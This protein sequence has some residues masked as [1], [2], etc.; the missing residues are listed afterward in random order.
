MIGAPPV[1]IAPAIRPILLLAALAA[2][3]CLPAGPGPWEGW[4][5]AAFAQDD[6]DDDDGGDDGSDDDDDDDPGDDDPGDDAADDDDDSAPSGGS[7]GAPAARDDTP[8]RDGD[9]PRAE[10]GQERTSQTRRRAAPAPAPPPPPA[11]APE[12]L[13]SDL[14]EADLALLSAEGFGLLER[15]SLAEVAVTLTRLSAPAG[16]TLEEARERVRQ[17]PSGQDADFNHYFRPASDPAPCAHEN[18]AALDLAGWPA[19]RP[20]TCRVTVPV[21]LIDTGVNPGHEILAGARLTM[22]SQADPGAE[23]SS[24][25][26]GTAVLS[27]LVGA[28]G[29]RVPGLIHEAEV[30]GVDIFTRAGGD[31]R[32]D[33]AAV[34]RGLDALTER[35]VRLVN[36]AL[37][38]PE[39]AVLRRVLDRLTA[40]EGGPL[41]GGAVIVAAVGNGGADAPPALP[42]AHQGVIAVTAVDR[43]G[44][45]YPRAQRGPHVDLAAPGVGLL[46]ATS[47]RGARPREGTSFAAPFVTAA[48]ALYLSRHPEAGAAEVA[49][50]LG[51]ASR[52]LGAPGPDEIFGQGLLSAAALCGE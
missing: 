43:R 2:G 1:P 16:L 9:R 19:E 5:S 52:D 22:L 44:R 20:A 31:E 24:A 7:G 6:D 27:L 35:G 25:I 49:E 40:P 11:F 36:M 14:S 37:A 42:A 17:L 51:A 3:L 33:A 38:G 12:L 46:A 32:A 4:T 10:R 34:V 15:S 18:C 47:I 13:V 41:P 29:S 30:V 48:A 23:P 50:A 39:N 28:P 45:V 8:E 26:H 21:G